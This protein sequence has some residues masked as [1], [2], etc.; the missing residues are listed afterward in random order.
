MIHLIPS[1]KKIS[2][3]EGYLVAKAVFYDA[4]NWDSRVLTAANKLPYDKDG[5]LLTIALTETAGEGY[6]LDI[7]T[8]AISV[9]AD[10]PAG[11][12]YAVQ[13]LRQL[14]SRKWYPVCTLRISLIS[15]TA[16]FITM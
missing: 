6:H 7:D 1:V 4:T 3:G 9:T 13:T 16:A 14:F 10:G 12:F 2:V 8:N 5:V 15:N 11:A